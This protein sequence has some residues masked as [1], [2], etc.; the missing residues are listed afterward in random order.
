[1]P[2]F[3]GATLRGALGFALKRAVCHVC[4]TPCR[5]CPVIN[6]CVY[7]SLFEGVAP[8]D[9]QIMRKYDHIPQPFVLV[10]NKQ[11]SPEISRGQ[12]YE[13][14]L[15][16]FG[17]SINHVPYATFAF[18]Q[19]GEK[20]LGKDQIPFE[21]ERVVQILTDGQERILY[22][23]A[24]SNILPAVPEKTATRSYCSG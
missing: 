9:R 16:V 11:D 7:S 15:R 2:D 3:R 20:G 21:V 22:N 18:M 5:E 10:V 1:M 12:S 17:Q 14:S 23:G 24:S 6:S 13:F 19:A 4:N 8:A